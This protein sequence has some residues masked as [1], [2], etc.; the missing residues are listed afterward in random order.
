VSGFRPNRNW[1]TEL[2]DAGGSVLVQLYCGRLEPTFG[3]NAASE[4][5]GRLRHWFAANGIDLAL[6]G[7]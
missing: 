1:L 2:G 7:C 6:I 4:F 5:A 3:S